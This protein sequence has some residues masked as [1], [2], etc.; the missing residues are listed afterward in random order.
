MKRA[1]QDIITFKADA[2]LLEAMKDIPNRSEF[3]RNAILAALDSA[4]PLC[5]G[6]GVLSQHQKRHLDDFLADHSLKECEECHDLKFVC[7]RTGESKS[8]RRVCF[9]PKKK[10]VSCNQST[11]MEEPSR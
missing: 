2:S 10:E 11:Q 4:C 6:T 9:N 1:K 3:I 7:S 8:K 5:S